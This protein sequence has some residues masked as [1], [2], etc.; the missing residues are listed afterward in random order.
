MIPIFGMGFI[1]ILFMVLFWGGL[2]TAIF[3]TANR[4]AATPQHLS[5]AEVLKI[6]YARGEITADEYKE[7]KDTLNLR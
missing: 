6:R 2:I 3:P 7:M 4:P 1:G 5:T